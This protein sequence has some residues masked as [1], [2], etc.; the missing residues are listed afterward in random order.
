M[1]PSHFLLRNLLTICLLAVWW[2]SA[3]A[4]EPTVGTGSDAEA[5]GDTASSWN[6]RSV[7][8]ARSNP[9]LARS[10]AEKALQLAEQQGERDVAA[11]A[12]VNIGRAELLLGNYPAA[13]RAMQTGLD[14]ARQ[15]AGPRDIAVAAESLAV[16]FDRVGLYEQSL[17]LHQEA[18]LQ[19]ESAND[20]ERMAQVL[21]NLGN[22]YDNLDQVPLS[23]SH[24]FRA[25]SLLDRIGAETGR[26]S[27]YNNLS[28]VSDATTPVSESLGLLDRAI[29]LYRE[30]N[31]Q[32]GLGLAYRNQAKFLI[33]AGR[34]DDARIAVQQARTI[35][36]STGH[37]LGLSA[38]HEA[39]AEL[40]MAEAEKGQS[41][42]HAM[43]AAGLALDQALVIAAELA[44]TDR[45]ERLLRLQSDWHEQRGDD[46]AA[47]ATLRR[48]EAIQSARAEE[49][50]TQRVEALT[51][52]YQSEQQQSTLRRLEAEAKVQS[53]ALTSTRWQRNT[54]LVVLVLLI[55]LGVVGTQWIRTRDRLLVTE[56]AQNAALQRTM[57]ALE[58]AHRNADEERRI[59]TE[60]L[61]LA[62]N[63]VQSSLKRVRAT[64]ERLLGSASLS[65]DSRL[66]LA[67]LATTTN[68]VVDTLANLVTLTSLERDQVSLSFTTV[69][70]SQLLDDLVIQA[71]ARAAEKRLRL[72]LTC[73]PPVRTVQAD[74]LRLTEAV[75]QLI[76]NAIKFS[77]PNRR[78]EVLFCNSGAATRIEVHDE[79]PGLSEADQ[80]R[81]FGRF[82]RLSAR[83]TGG[84]RST[85]LG[86][87]L[88]KRIAELHGGTA[89]FGPS[90]LQGGICFFIELPG[91]DHNIDKL[92]P[93]PGL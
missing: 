2:S 80:R 43:L 64:V 41:A 78:I 45:Q 13:I 46:K 8:V 21:V 9:E 63:D 27:I 66:Q 19:F 67:G 77:P 72:S 56:R 14:A 53:D 38:A 30:E 93:H 48:A 69:D 82:Q 49:R 81:V 11:M 57:A 17:R 71:E 65:A 33:Q 26:A 15:S 37:R 83:P 84:E 90:R 42:E 68:E 54:F 62:A 24:Y 86:L 44:D 25:L 89:G 32:I 60:L 6:K 31:N 34:L 70:L 36:E 50:R 74:R 76:G 28:Q 91:P 29:A 10:H 79:G 20:L 85:G 35:A 4:A 51:A 58:Q 47:L 12:R 18:L 87:A 55:V 75:E 3:A 88:V 22:L 61:A 23:R 40:H 7:A 52:Q 1:L 5:G 59:N 73:A 16:A 92:L 39:A